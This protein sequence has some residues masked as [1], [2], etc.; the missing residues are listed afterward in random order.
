MRLLTSRSA[1]TTCVVATYVRRSDIPPRIDKSH[2]D[3]ITEIILVRNHRFIWH[4]GNSGM[5]GLR[6]QTFNL[7]LSTGPS[8]SVAQREIYRIEYYN[9]RDRKLVW[10]RRILDVGYQDIFDSSTA[11]ALMWIPSIDNISTLGSSSDYS[12]I[13]FEF[14]RRYPCTT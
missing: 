13:G 4:G 12:T 6:G 14:S 1:L 10:K 11:I 3:I 8:R 5:C 7:M 2:I 9:E